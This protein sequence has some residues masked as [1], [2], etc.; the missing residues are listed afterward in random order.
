[1]MHIKKE[2]EMKRTH[3][4]LWLVIV[5]MFFGC[6]GNL[7]QPSL[8]NS[9]ETEL[10]IAG[11]A[12]Q[13]TAIAKLDSTLP[14]GTIYKLPGDTT[15][16]YASGGELLQDGSWVGNFK[17]SFY[18]VH[19]YSLMNV[20]FDSLTTVTIDSPSN[21]TYFDSTGTWVSLAFGETV[22]AEAV[23]VGTAGSASIS[24]STGSEF[25]DDDIQSGN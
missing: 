1:M 17:D 3:V 11:L 24:V 12:K 21:V 7:T 5:V 14:S 23:K 4:V 22:S 15:T 2:F 8:L 19:L 13:R 6:E 25:D 10:S 20:V 9:H 16:Y 18:E